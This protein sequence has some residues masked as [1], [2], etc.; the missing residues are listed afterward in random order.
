M[1]K[2]LEAEGFALATTIREAG[3]SV[4]IPLVAIFRRS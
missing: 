1:D 4:D 2:E 3:L